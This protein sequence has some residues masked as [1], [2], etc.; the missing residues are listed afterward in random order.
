MRC[1]DAY[2]GV[3]TRFWR[4]NPNPYV[5]PVPHAEL[6]GGGHRCVCVTD[7]HDVVAVGFKTRTGHI[8]GLQSIR[9]GA[10]AV[11]LSTLR[12]SGGR[13]LD[14][15]GDG[16]RAYY[17]RHGYRV[18]ESAPWDESLAPSNWPYPEAEPRP[19]WHLME[20]IEA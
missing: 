19:D 18:I 12:R 20:R 11:I 5:T 2:P 10:G 7:G 15:L 17:E 4:D 16:L 6:F 8:G 14:C 9:P 13:T 3:L 1:V